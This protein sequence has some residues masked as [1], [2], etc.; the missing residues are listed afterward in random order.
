MSFALKIKIKFELK[1]RK[2]FQI[3]LQDGRCPIAHT[4][5]KTKNNK[6]E[7]W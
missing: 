7:T 1:N 4:P 3:V 2:Y 5:I 6:G